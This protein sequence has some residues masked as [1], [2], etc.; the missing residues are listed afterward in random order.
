MFTSSGKRTEIPFSSN[1]CMDGSGFLIDLIMHVCVF[2][3][4][5]TRETEV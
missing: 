1:S 2:S 4:S 3:G 5:Q